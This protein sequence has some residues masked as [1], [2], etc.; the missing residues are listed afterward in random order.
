MRVRLKLRSPRVEDRHAPDLGPQVL[1]IAG[2]VQETLGDGAKEQPIER[3]RIGEDEWAEVL[4]QGKNRVFIRRV[5]DFT[6]SVGQPSGSGDALAFGAMP[7]AAGVISTP[8]MATGVTA[9]FVAAQGRGVAQL[10]GPKRPVLL[11]AQRMAIALQ[12]GLAM[13]THDIGDF[14]GGATHGN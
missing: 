13:L 1:G 4:G 6:L 5:K 3:A 12:E 2:D 9:G 14:E 11:T 8:L 10:D 7:V